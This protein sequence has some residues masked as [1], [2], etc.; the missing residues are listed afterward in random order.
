CCRAAPVPGAKAAGGFAPERC[1]AVQGG[2]ALSA[3]L[4]F[5]VAAAWMI[6]FVANLAAPALPPRSHTLIESV[7]ALAFLSI[8]PLALALRTRRNWRRDRSPGVGYGDRPSLTDCCT[9]FR[10]RTG[11]C[12]GLPLTRQRRASEQMFG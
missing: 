9:H 11:E 8:A 10:K 7:D 6:D 3:R 4:A 2:G 1:G 12:A 5:L